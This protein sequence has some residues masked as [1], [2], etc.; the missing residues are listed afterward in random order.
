MCPGPPLTGAAEIIQRRDASRLSGLVLGF[1]LVVCC[2][3]TAFGM[4]LGDAMIVVPNMGGAVVTVLQI[5]LL[6]KYGGRTPASDLDESS[7]VDEDVSDR[8]ELNRAP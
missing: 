1:S 2:L 4:M 8:V 6:V 7:V 5:V 3:W